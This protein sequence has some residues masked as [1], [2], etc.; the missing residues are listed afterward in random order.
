[1]THLS[2]SGVGTHELNDILTSGSG[3]CHAEVG[4]MRDTVLH[5]LHLNLMMHWCGKMWSG[6]GG[7]RQAKLVHSGGVLYDF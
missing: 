6:G 4:D 5:I 7:L 1:M 2:T 3:P